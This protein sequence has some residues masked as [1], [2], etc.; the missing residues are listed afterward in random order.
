[1]RRSVRS[2]AFNGAEATQFVAGFPII[3]GAYYFLYRVPLALAL[4][5]MSALAFV[6]T[7]LLRL[8]QWASGDPQFFANHPVLLAEGAPGIDLMEWRKPVLAGDT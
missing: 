7:L 6:L 8:M 1:A 2:P 4:C 5:I 3:L